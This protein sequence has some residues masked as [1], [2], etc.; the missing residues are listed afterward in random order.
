[1][2][3]MFAVH[4]NRLAKAYGSVRHTRYGSFSYEPHPG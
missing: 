4:L 2:P 3:E 1:M